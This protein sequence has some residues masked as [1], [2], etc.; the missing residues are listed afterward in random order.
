MPGNYYELPGFTGNM[1]T[2][3]FAT[4]YVSR[5]KFMKKG[6]ELRIWFGEDLDNFYDGDNSGRHCVE[7]VS[8]MLKYFYIKE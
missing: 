7:I 8:N 4:D 3:L 2:I 6:H 1:D 5:P